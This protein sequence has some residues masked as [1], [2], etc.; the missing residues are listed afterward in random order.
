MQGNLQL[1]QNIKNS[2]LASYRHRQLEAV[3]T[4]R[5]ARRRG[6]HI[7]LSPVSPKEGFW[8]SFLRE[9]ESTPGP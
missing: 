1:I 6:S 5:V 4:H 8:Y 7:L 9:A 3:E 2:V